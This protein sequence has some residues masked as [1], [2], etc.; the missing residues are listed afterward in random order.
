MSESTRRAPTENDYPA[1]AFFAVYRG[2]KTGVFPTLAQL[3]KNIEGYTAAVWE[4][5]NNKAHAENFAKTG[6]VPNGATPVKPGAHSTPG[7]RR[8]TSLAGNSSAGRFAPPASR[9]GNAGASLAGAGTKSMSA[10]AGA[11]VPAPAPLAPTKSV[12]VFNNSPTRAGRPTV[13]ATEPVRAEPGSSRS[14][15]VSVTTSAS[16]IVSRT[17]SGSTDDT[18]L[19]LGKEDKIEVWTD[20]SCLAN[21]KDNPRAAY[22]VYFGDGDPRNDAG[23]VPGVQTNNRGEILGVIRALEIIDENVSELTVYTDSQYII[24]CPE[25]LPGWIARG[26]INSSKKPVANYSMIRYMAAL[27][28]RRGDR[29]KLVYVAGHKDNAGNNAVDALARQAASS[30]PNIPPEV[31]WDAKR[32]ALE[33]RP[34]PAKKGKPLVKAVPSSAVSSPPA[35]RTPI[36]KGSIARAIERAPAPA[37]QPDSDEFSESSSAG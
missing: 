27:M 13:T 24:K 12:P 3:V 1:T 30:I 35:Q 7:A 23:R 34:A 31:D 26:G 10:L 25:W 20:G 2:H 29:L 8:T 15:P 19:G 11:S 5:F 28:Q 22:G 16:S 33:K 37:A 32:Y 14:N 17:M 21:G 18:D 9:V 4:V 36:A 6:V